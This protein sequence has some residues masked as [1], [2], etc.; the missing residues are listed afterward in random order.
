MLSNLP[1][2]ERVHFFGFEVTSDNLVVYHIA[3]DQLNPMQFN[4]GDEGHAI[5]GET[6]FSKSPKMD[7]DKASLAEEPCRGGQEP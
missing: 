1:K 6:E 2:S 7:E 4:P 5:T 3:F